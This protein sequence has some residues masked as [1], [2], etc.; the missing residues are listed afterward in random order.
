VTKH[1]VQSFIHFDVFATMGLQDSFP[2]YGGRGPS[3]LRLGIALG[4]IATIFIFLRVYVRLRVTQFGTASLIWALLAWGFTAITQV[5][6]IVSVLHGLGNHI[7]VVTETGELHNFLLF[8]WTTVFFF[9][10]AI[11]VGKVAVAMF[12]IEMNQQTSP[13]IP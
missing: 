4:S 2:A 9:N 13:W 10:I 8:T 3:D 1:H 5:L 12:L 11:P 6:G 7:S